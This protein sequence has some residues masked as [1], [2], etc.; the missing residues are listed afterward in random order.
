MS[1]Q[2][3]VTLEDSANL[4]VLVKNS[5]GVPINADATPTF[6]VYAS[7][8][9]LT[10]QTGS[11]SFKDTGSITGATNASPIVVTSASHG[12]SVGTRVTITGV[13]G[14][15]AA[16]GTFTISAADTNTFTLSGSTGNSAYTSGGA[17]NVTGLY[18]VS[19]TCSAANGYE[20]GETYSVLVSGLISSAGWGDI[21]SL[22]VV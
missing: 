5:S 3:F 18:K 9:L 2:G 15:T 7:S 4:V 8:G 19:L 13:G 11:A 21:L 14:N 12:L 10:G 1:F 20:A 17:W 6:R 16:N 22:G